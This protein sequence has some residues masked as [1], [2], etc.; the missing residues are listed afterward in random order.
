MLGMAEAVARVERAIAGGE[1][2]LLYG[3][4]DVDGT[5][6]VVTTENRDRDAGAEACGFMYRARI[7][8]KP[9]CS[10]AC[11]RRLT[12]RACGW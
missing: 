8:Y 10:R 4:Y 1:T 6:A 11:W 5:T 2:I 3:D 9:G 7:R 12:Q